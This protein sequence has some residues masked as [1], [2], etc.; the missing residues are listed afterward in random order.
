MKMLKYP[1]N[2]PSFKQSLAM[3]DLIDSIMPDHTDYVLIGIDVRDMQS[4]VITNASEKQMECLVKLAQIVIEDEKKS[5][6]VVLN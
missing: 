4:Y 2:D 1:N 3:K 6:H 5:L